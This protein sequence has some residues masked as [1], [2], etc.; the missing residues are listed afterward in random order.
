MGGTRTRH[1]EGVK[2]QADPHGGHEWQAEA[3][4]LFLTGPRGR[5][6]SLEV[7]GFLLGTKCPRPPG[8]PSFRSAEGR[9]CR[10]CGVEG[11]AGGGRLS[12][13]VKGP[14]VVGVNAP[15][16][17]EVRAPSPSR[18]GS[19]VSWAQT[20]RNNQ[21][22]EPEFLR[23]WRMYQDAPG[24]SPWASRMFNSEGFYVA[25]FFSNAR[26]ISCYAIR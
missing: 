17:R 25:F 15:A 3:A 8:G 22:S 19:P 21:T 20:M 9:R 7:W 14:C 4:I 1:L 6:A 23:T 12:L 10:R 18:W 11:P 5:T 13:P 26:N 24:T 16:Q 2:P